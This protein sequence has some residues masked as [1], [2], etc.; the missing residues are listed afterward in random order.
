M[1]DFNLAEA[2]VAIKPAKATSHFI[3][4]NFKVEEYEF[5]SPF[6]LAIPNTVGPEIIELL[7]R[8]VETDNTT[9]LN[10]VLKEITIGPDFQEN[11]ADE[12]LDALISTRPT[13]LLLNQNKKYESTMFWLS[14]TVTSEYFEGELP[15]GS[16]AFTAK[17]NRETLS[18]LLKVIS[19]DDIDFDTSIR[20][21][22]Y[23]APKTL[24]LKKPIDF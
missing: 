8:M 4:L 17:A 7:N 18:K 2:V 20:N 14:F 9:A 15:T 3:N 13:S 22:S 23:N 11:F 5:S 19:S 21:V 12:R 16:I 6:G 24:S 10:I 1:T